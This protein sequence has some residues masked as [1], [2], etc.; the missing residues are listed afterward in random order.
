MAGL[1]SFLIAHLIYTNAFRSGRS[2]RFKI[3]AILPFVVYGVFIYAFLSPGL[4]GMAIREFSL[5]GR[6]K[7]RYSRTFRRM[8]SYMRGSAG[9]KMNLAARLSFMITALTKQS[10]VAASSC[11]KGNSST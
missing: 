5:G 7:H 1:I 9:V 4:N 10:A 11:T 2:F 8:K 3:V 6:R